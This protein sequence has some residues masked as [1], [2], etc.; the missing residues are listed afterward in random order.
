MTYAPIDIEKAI[1]RE[2][3]RRRLS[4]RTAKTYANCINKF[5]AKTGKTIDK[6]SKGDAS[7]YLYHLSEKKKLGSTINVNLMALRFLFMDILKK[8]VRFDIKYSKIPLKLPVVLTKDEVKK[9][10][11]SI[12]N[13][14]HR[15]MIELM[16]SAGL[17]LSEM[18]N[19][20]VRD[21][22][23]KNNYGFVRQGKG[24]KDRL[25]ILSQKLKPKIQEL[26]AGKQRDDLI[27]ISNLSKKYS[28]RTIQK[29]ID[30]ATSIAEI[31]KNV[32][33]H[34]LRHSFATHLIEDGCS[35]LEVQNL[36]GHISPETTMIY[37]H[38]AAPNMLKIKSPIDS[39]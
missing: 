4:Q 28:P 17:R 25:F 14:K 36:L 27:F 22:D 37:V 35:L 31:D 21:I 7:D 34:T 12:D 5:I 24:A 1:W 38:L 29:I 9:L 19:M 8:N 39:L 33:P 10:I 15:L 6:I 3:E 26:I 11:D 2:C 20:K 18:L 23:F 13:E 16:Y 32:H 30:K